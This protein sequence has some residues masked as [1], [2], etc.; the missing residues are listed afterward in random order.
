MMTIGPKLLAASGKCP[1]CGEKLLIHGVCR[2]AS[3]PPEDGQVTIH[4]TDPLL[5]PIDVADARA[6][7]TACGVPIPAEETDTPS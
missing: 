7:L 6:H 5:D 4:I 3:D 1:A 2:I